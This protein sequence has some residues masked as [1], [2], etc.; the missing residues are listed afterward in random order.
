MKEVI[1]LPAKQRVVID[2]IEDQET[3]TSSG[4]ILPAGTDDTRPGMG[5]VVAVGNGDG[6]H[7]MDYMVGQTVCYSKFAGLD[8][9]LN[10]HTYGERVY[11]VMNQMDIMM[12]VEEVI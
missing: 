11:K 8:V 12:V 1:A 3:Q 7:P 5:Q 6:D 10:L 2:P 4:I 9:K